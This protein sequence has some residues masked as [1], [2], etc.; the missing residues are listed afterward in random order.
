M[1]YASTRAELISTL[2]LRTQRLQG[3]LVATTKSDLTFP[4]STE[5]SISLSDLSIRERELADVKAAEAEGAHGTT[6]RA[7]V[8]SSSGISFPVSEDARNCLSALRAG[9][10]EELI[11]LVPV[12]VK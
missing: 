1:L 3:Q 7:T 6:K 10:E 4:S 12:L 5:P 11:Q 9:E 2:G 8:V